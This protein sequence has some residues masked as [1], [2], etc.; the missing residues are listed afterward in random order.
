MGAGVPVCLPGQCYVP[1][2]GN[3]EQMGGLMEAMIP[4][5]LAGRSPLSLQQVPDLPHQ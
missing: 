1:G 5:P 2:V 4:L 3:G